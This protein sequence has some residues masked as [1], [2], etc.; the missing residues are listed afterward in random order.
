MSIA[1]TAEYTVRDQERMQL[2]GRYFQWQADLAA[3]A[4]GR[5]VIEVGCGLGNFTQHLIDREIV[6]ATDIESSCTALLAARFPKSDNLVIHTASVLSPEFASMERYKPDSVVCLNV[7]EH[8]E[9]DTLALHQMHHVLQAGGR[10]ALIVPAFMALYGPI[11]RLLGHYRR[12]SKKSIVRLAHATGFNVIALRYMNTVGCL[13]WWVNS[14]ILRKT[15]QSETQ[16]KLFDRWVVPIMRR[17]EDV[18][19]PPFGQSLFV[20]LEKPMRSAQ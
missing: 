15:E 19:P 1:T 12:Y 2:A 20:I 5:R 13:G 10:V 11:D 6:V 17:A 4:V 16:I 3:S 8:V 18:L 7:L 14:H 9:D